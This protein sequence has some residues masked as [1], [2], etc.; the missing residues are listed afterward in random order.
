MDLS[1]QSGWPLSF[2][3]RLPEREL[4]LWAKYAQQ[5]GFPNRR[6]ELGLALITKWI[7]MTMGGVERPDLRDF[8]FD[9]PEEDHEMTDDELEALKADIGFNPING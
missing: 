5:K 4:S 6:H 8:L 3:E 2:I 9:P 1:L 7:A